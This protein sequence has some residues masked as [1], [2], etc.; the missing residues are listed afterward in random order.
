MKNNTVIVLTL[1]AL[2]L[3]YKYVA[4]LFPSLIGAEL[5]QS[6]GYDGVMLAVMAS[7]YYYSYTFMQ[8]IA[9]LI[10]SYL[11]SIMLFFIFGF[12]VGCF[13]LSFELCREINALYVMG[14]SVAF[15]N[16]GEGLLG[17]FIEP[18]IGHILDVSKVESTFT[19]ANYQLALSALPCCFILSSFVLIFIKRNRIAVACK[20]LGF[21]EYAR[22]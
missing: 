20:K 4:Q 19:L 8:I 14:L 15:I 1:C 16:S 13:M 11:S 9:G 12:S 22:I 21:K 2:F 10:F 18:F 3:F 7:S 6:Y 17:S 5:M